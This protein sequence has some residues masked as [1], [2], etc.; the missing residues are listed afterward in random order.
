VQLSNYQTITL[1][2]REILQLISLCLGKTNLNILNIWMTLSHEGA[3]CGMNYS[4]Q[5]SNLWSTNQ[6]L[7]T[8]DY[9]SVSIAALLATVLTDSKLLAHIPK[10]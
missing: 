7:A 10:L 8:K 5:E 6:L 9:I 3:F 2:L 4:V 1:Y